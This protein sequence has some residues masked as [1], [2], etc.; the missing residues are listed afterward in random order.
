[1][2]CTHRQYNILIFLYQ[3]PGRSAFAP[4]IQA[5]AQ[6]PCVYIPGHVNMGADI[7]SMQG[8][9]SGEWVLPLHNSFFHRIAH[10]CDLKS[11]FEGEK[12]YVLIITSLY[13][14]I[15]R[16][17]KFSILKVRIVRL[18]VAITFIF[19]FSGGNGLPYSP[20]LETSD[21][22]SN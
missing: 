20:S 11:S 9:R 1:M 6:D 14:A 15:L 5:D 2:C 8:P 22:Q 17:L 12:Y 7:L 19:L 18:K 21:N 4:L 10:I 3:P 13:H 16:I